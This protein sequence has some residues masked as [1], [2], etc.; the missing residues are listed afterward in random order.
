MRDT[1]P[2]LIQDLHAGAQHIARIINDMRDF[3]RPG[4]RRGQEPVCLND[5]VQR[6]VRLLHHLIHRK[7]THFQ[8][9]LAASLPPVWG[10][11][12]HL[13][14]VVVNLVVNALE[15]LPD[16]GCGVCVTTYSVPEDHT[17]V[18]EVADQGVGIAPQHL[19]RVCDPFFTTKAAWGGTGLGLAITATL[20]HAHG[21]RLTVQSTLGQGTCVCV[22]LPSADPTL[23]ATA[24]RS[25]EAR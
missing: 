4:A 23:A 14:H 22:T 11:A 13:A 19:A 8:V 20:V 18:L 24:A 17:L 10:D 5:T 7:T 1:L 9:D 6:G 25:A 16:A 15:A 3:A 2:L 12:Q 21:G